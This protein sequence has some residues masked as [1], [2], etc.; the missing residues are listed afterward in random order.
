[1]NASMESHQPALRMVQRYSSPSTGLVIE[2]FSLR[3]PELVLRWTHYTNIV[4][5]E[6]LLTQS[7]PLVTTPS[8]L[9]AVVML[10]G[11]LDLY[12]HEQ[13]LGAAPGQSVLLPVST[14]QR[15]R[16]QA[17]TYLDLEWTDPI[18]A[19]RIQPALLAPPD[20]R[21]VQRVV[22]DLK[23]PAADQ[24]STL[25]LALRLFRE[26]GAPV[27][28]ALDA[29]DGEPSDRDRLLARAMEEQLEHLASRATTIHLGDSARLSPRQLQRVVHE[30][31][32]RYG[33]NAGNWR[34]TR[35]RWRVQLAAVLLSR[36]ELTIAEIA[37]EVG[38][39]SPN[40]LARAFAKAGLP[41]PAEVRRALSEND[42]VR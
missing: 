16:W 24:R 6:R 2:V 30:F 13:H 23:D 25:A 40:G 15:A 32:A 11:K 4:V 28:A 8:R 29:L 27:P 3:R 38:Y 42:P 10:D 19:A 41:T 1:M 12:H 14:T 35:N 7:F 36:A 20:P 33:M 9:I 26:I 31:H 37:A 21:D 34:D 5:D 39:G 22:S 17:A 18:E